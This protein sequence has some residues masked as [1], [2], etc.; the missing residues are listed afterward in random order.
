MTPR[1][2][3]DT[4]TA[5]V[6]CKTSRHMTV[7]SFQVHRNCSVPSRESKIQQSC[8]FRR[9][10]TAVDAASRLR[11]WVMGTLLAPLVQRV[12]SQLLWHSRHGRWND[13]RAGVKW[14]LYMSRDS[15]HVTSLVCTSW[16]FHVSC[17]YLRYDARVGVT[18]L[19]C[20]LRDLFACDVTR[21]YVKGLSLPCVICLPPKWR[22]STCHVTPWCLM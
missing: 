13:A 4:S 9:S 14:L 17:H 8:Y 20:V 1:D 6:H 16:L 7:H 2:K 10:E 3:Y 12:L 11:K 19:G 21:L 15:L 5:H 18:W 22:P